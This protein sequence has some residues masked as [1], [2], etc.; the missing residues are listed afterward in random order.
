MKN[1]KIKG[2][3][4]GFMALCAIFSATFA[5]YGTTNAEDTTF[6]AEEAGSDSSY[7][8]RDYEGYVAVFIEGE[9]DLPTTVTDIQVSTLREFDRL[10]LETGMKVASHDRLVMIL[11]DLGS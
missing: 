10:L 9:P 11:E 6:K 5:L 2:F 8:L 1:N 3:L 4:L 7:V